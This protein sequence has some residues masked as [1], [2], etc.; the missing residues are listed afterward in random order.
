MPRTRVPCRFSLS[1]SIAGSLLPH[2]AAFPTFKL[3][4]ATD[5]T[6]CTPVEITITSSQPPIVLELR[7]QP[8]SGAAATTISM[9]EL[10]SSTIHMSFVPDVPVGYSIG[11]LLTDRSGSTRTNFFRISDSSCPVGNDSEGPSSHLTSPSRSPLGPWF[12]TTFV[13]SSSRPSSAVDS[14]PSDPPLSTPRAVTSASRSQVP[15][16]P[17]A[18]IPSFPIST[19]TPIST[20]STSSISPIITAP[21]GATSNS[22]FLTSFL[23]SATHSHTSALPSSSSTFTQTSDELRPA[24]SPGMIAG[25]SVLCIIALALILLA[26]WML[27]RKRRRRRM[28]TEQRTP[29]PVWL[30]AFAAPGSRRGVCGPRSASLRPDSSM[31]LQYAS[32]VSPTDGRAVP[33]WGSTEKMADALAAAAGKENDDASF[34]SERPSSLIVEP[35]LSEPDVAAHRHAAPERP[36]WRSQIEP[37]ARPTGSAKASSAVRGTMTS[38]STP[39]TRTAVTPSLFSRVTAM[40]SWVGS[41]ISSQASS[42]RVTRASS[43]RVAVD[44]GVRLAGGP[45]DMDVVTVAGF[46]SRA[47]VSTESTLPPPYVESRSSGTI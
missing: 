22:S 15:I 13:L 19:V 2:V 6:R 33:V 34:S 5:L 23:S 40:T 27:V 31:L 21:D 43:R 42:G 35:R 17:S 30:P 37:L 38:A 14:D 24:M 29:W 9:G 18:T 46:D 36:F 11:F 41:P 3:N 25:V 39:T 12:S 20:V 10:A 47:S 28:S 45:L 8:P 32:P 1:L 26:L 7:A 16:P 44:G 4:P